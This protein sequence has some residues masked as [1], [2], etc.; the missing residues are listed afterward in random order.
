MAKEKAS[1]I[2]RYILENAGRRS[3]LSYLRARPYY[4]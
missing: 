4:G 3:N 2:F 1:P